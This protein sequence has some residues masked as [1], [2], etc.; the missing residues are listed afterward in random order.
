MTVAPRPHTTCKGCATSPP[1]G[2][3]ELGVPEGRGNI[4]G[5]GLPAPEGHRNLAGAQAKRSHRSATARSLASRR[6]AGRPVSRYRSPIRSSPARFHNAAT[7]NETD[8]SRGPPGR[9]FIGRIHRWFH[10]RLSSDAPPGQGRGIRESPRFRPSG[11]LA[12]R[13]HTQL[14]KLCYLPAPE[15][16]RSLAGAQGKRSHRLA[17]RKHDTP[18]VVVERRPGTRVSPLIRPTPSTG[19]ST[20]PAPRTS[21]RSPRP[22]RPFHRPGSPRANPS[23]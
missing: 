12:P 21:L 23:P 6:A 13:P 2:A 20:A 18:V 3:S 9:P 10:H 1:G 4:V 14:A 15:G 16:P 19:S 7:K 17:R 8:L 22:S 11:F 5:P